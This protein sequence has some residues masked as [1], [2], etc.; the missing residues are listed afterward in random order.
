MSRHRAERRRQN[1][2]DTQDQSA[3]APTVKTHIKML[4]TKTPTRFIGLD[5]AR[6]LTAYC[7]VLVHLDYIC[8]SPPG[9][10]SLIRAR[11]FGFPVIILSSF[12]TL[13]LALLRSPQQ[14]LRQFIN[15]RFWRIQI[16][17]LVW[18]ALYW[19]FHQAFLILTQHGTWT[20]PSPTLFL[21]GYRHL[22]FLQFAFLGA[23]VVAPPVR[24]AA[25][26]PQ[27]AGWFALACFTIAGGCGALRPALQQYCSLYIVPQ[28][29]LDMRILVQETVRFAMYAPLGIGLAWLAPTLAAWSQRPSPRLLSGGLVIVTLAAHL[30]DEGAFSRAAYGLAVFLFLLQ[31]ITAFDWSITRLIAKY[32]YAIYIVHAGIAQITANGLGWLGVAYTPTVVFVGSVAVF[33]ASLLVSIGLH[34]LNPAEWFIPLVTRPTHS[35]ST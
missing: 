9:L 1:T 8:G 14:S 5:L 15:K 34:R 4:Q 23:L 32:S 29:A 17:L 26:Y 10:E 21:S 20:W 6:A 16:P 35:A 31:P 12:F 7:I 18:T 30:G 11:D 2:I 27:H 13:T 24:Y 19:I 3:Y 33:G 25:R 28:V 22:W